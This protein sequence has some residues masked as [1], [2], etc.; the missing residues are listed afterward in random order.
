[1]VWK[2]NTTK[3]LTP[4]TSW[5]DDDGIQHPSNWTRWSNETKASYKVTWGEDPV[6]VKY[7]GRFYHSS[8]D[9][10]P[11][12]DL[13]TFFIEQKKNEANDLLHETDWYIIRKQEKGTAIPKK[14]SD[15]RD[16]IRTACAGIETKIKNAANVGILKTLFD[17]KGDGSKS[18][19]DCYPDRLQ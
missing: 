5:T 3:I 2:Y 16:A 15:Y 18:D 17:T 7:D 4:G 11:I 9:P 13:R 8:G 14:V 12:E 1:M 6:K 19:M 10:R